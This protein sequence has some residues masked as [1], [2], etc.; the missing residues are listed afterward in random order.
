MNLHRD[1]LLAVLD[2]DESLLERLCDEG[3]V[4]RDEAQ[5]RAVHVERARVVYTLVHELDVNWA[6]VEVI[7]RMRED[8][9]ATRAQVVELVELV[10]R[11][12][13]G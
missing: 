10:R 7:L 13:G 2:G 3:L 1:V 5:L 8:L 11:S 12:R 9:V 4:P 6:G